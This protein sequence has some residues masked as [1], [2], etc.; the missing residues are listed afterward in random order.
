LQII[1]CIGMELEKEKPN[2]P[3]DFFNRSEITYLDE[4]KEKTLHILYVRY[5]DQIF[6]EFTPFHQD[7]IFG[8]GESSVYFKDI[9]ALVCLLKD[10]ELRSKKRL[11]INS[12]YEFASYFEGINFNKI[13]EIF[14]NIKQKK[15]VE[16]Q[17]PNEFFVQPR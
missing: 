5:F 13:Q 4:G 3:E 6:Q 9:V 8:V 14:K 12:K 16:I 11:Y 1:D 17:S 7:P 15:R 2:T 10:P